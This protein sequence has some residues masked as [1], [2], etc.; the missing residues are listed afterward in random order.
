MRLCCQDHL[1]PGASFEE[2]FT[3]LREVGFTAVEVDGAHLWT[4]LD[5]ITEASRSAELPVAAVCRGFDGCLLD[6]NPAE[7]QK[8]ADGLKKLLAMCQDLGGAQ[9]RTGG[10]RWTKLAR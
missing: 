8:V 2:R 3:R 4:E 6:T 1:M 5:E 9:V 10:L 7:R